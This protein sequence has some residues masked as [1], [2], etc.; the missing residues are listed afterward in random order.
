MRGS[1]LG[2]QPPSGHQ[3][4]R[5]RDHVLGRVVGFGEQ[6]FDRQP[7]E[8]VDLHL[9]PGGVAQEGGVLLSVARHHHG[10]AAIDEQFGADDEIG[11]VRDEEQH[12]A[13]KIDRLARPVAQVHHF[14]VRVEFVLA[15]R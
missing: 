6:G 14:A 15:D 3:L 13:G 8:R 1:P 10:T 9:K 11:L 4:G 12:G 5:R 2:G 7:V